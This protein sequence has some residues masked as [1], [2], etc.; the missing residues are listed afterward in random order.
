MRSAPRRKLLVGAASAMGMV[1]PL[2]LMP[3]TREASMAATEGAEPVLHEF[4]RLRVKEYLNAVAWNSDGSRLAAMSNFE[5][6]I[7][8]WET[9]SWNVVN[10]FEANVYSSFNS[11]AYLPDGSLL[12]TAPVGKSIGGESKFGTVAL[13]L[14]DADGGRLLRNIPDPIPDAGFK[15]GPAINFTVSTDGAWIAGIMVGGHIL[16]FETHTWTLAKHFL[17]PPTTQHPDVAWSVA[18]SP[19]GKELGVGTIF[20]YVHIFELGSGKNPPLVP[21]VLRRCSV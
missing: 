6:L 14:W 7:T 4:R 15:I 10:E 19:D 16:I 5:R 11:L 2:K 17:V 13:L 20:G 1:G 12:T 21:R 9:G 18:F 3:G 8:V